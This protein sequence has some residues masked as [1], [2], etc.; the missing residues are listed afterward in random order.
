MYDFCNKPYTPYWESVVSNGIFYDVMFY[1]VKGLRK[2]DKVFS[3]IVF[4]ILYL[5]QYA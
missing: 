5:I 1:G 2:V 3:G 4:L